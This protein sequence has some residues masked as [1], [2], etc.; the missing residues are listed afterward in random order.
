M[1]GLR[2]IAVVAVV[3]VHA[4]LFGEAIDSSLGGRLLAHLNLGVT[5]FFLVSG[6]L[7]YRPFVAL[8]NSGAPPPRTRDYAKRRALR[9]LPAYWLVLTVLTL[10]RGLTG[11]HES[12]WAGQYSLLQTLPLF[13]GTGCS[14]AITECGLAQTWSLVVEFTFYALLPVYVI[15]AARL[16]PSGGVT[17]W[18]TYELAG[19][20]ALAAVSVAVGP[21]ASDGDPDTWTGGTVAGYGLWF[22]LGMALAI[23]SVGFENRKPPLPVRMAITR[24]GWL[25]WRRWSSTS[26]S[27]STCRPAR[28]WSTPPAGSWPTSRSG[29]SPCCWWRRPPSTHGPRRFPPGC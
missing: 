5:I 22:A 20:A 16:A 26:C 10:A 17:R 14:S 25:C 2:G 19:L 13:E 7:L 18:M 21:T 4:A 9:I 23:T 6:F 1:D 8:R 28:S 3:A 27:R 29:S 24:P 12:N 11:V 15:L